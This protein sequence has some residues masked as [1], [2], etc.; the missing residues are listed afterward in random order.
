[1]KSKGVEEGQK[2]QFMFA[3]VG[4]CIICSAEFWV[5]RYLIIVFG[6]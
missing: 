4:M 1:M 2:V 5:G 6:L 3:S